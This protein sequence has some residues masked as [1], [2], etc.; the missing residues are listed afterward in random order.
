MLA[1]LDAG[2]TPGK[3]KSLESMLIR[4]FGESVLQ[5][6]FS[7]LSHDRLMAASHDCVKQAV[8]RREPQAEIIATRLLE[9]PATY[10]AW[11]SE[12]AGMMRSVA[13]ERLP[14]A[15]RA[16]MLSASFSLIHRKG[17]FEYMRERKLRGPERQALVQHF[18]P[19]RDFADSVRSEHTHYVRSAVSYLCVG[20]LGRDLMFDTLFE[21]PLSEY[22]EIYNEYFF[23]HCDQIVAD[24]DTVSLPIDMLTSMKNRVS[25]WR[26]AL[27]ALTQSQSGTWR[28][29]KF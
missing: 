20:H 17:L 22:E 29:P 5:P 13:V 26:R 9:S 21:E 12:H 11:E 28:R 14:A 27:L 15:Q 24:S 16:A 7:H 18:F 10:G 3:K 4:R 6:A 23:A 19:Q 2:M 25:D 1:E 8:I